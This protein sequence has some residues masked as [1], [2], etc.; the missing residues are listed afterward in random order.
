MRKTSIKKDLIFTL[1]VL[2]AIALIAM[3]LVSFIYSEHHAHEAF[4]ANLVRSAKLIFGLIKHEI[5][6]EKDLNFLTEISPA[7][8]QRIF[9][10]YEYKLHAQAW[11]G[12]ELI[13]NSDNL[14]KSPKP[15]HEGFGDISVDENNWR[16]FS[17]YDS[18]S[19]IRILVAEKDLVRNDLIFEIFLSFLIPLL[20]SLPPLFLI[21]AVTVNKKL[22]PLKNLAAKIEKMSLQ[23][24]QQLQDHDLPSELAP[25]VSSFNSL[26]A[27]L[28][29]LID[30][31]RN[32]TNYAAHELKTP[33]AAISVQ[34]HLL[35]KNKDQELEKKYSQDLFEGINRATH[36]INQLLTLS[37]LEID[38][39]EIEKEVISLK[40]LTKSL[41]K[42][43]APKAE[44]KNLEIEFICEVAAEKNFIK[45][46]KT[47][48]EI[49]LGNLLDNAI[50]YSSRDKKISILIFE[51]NNFL[52]FKISNHGEK[53][54]PEEIEKI[55]NN[56]YRVS[57]VNVD[58]D[59]IGCGLGLAIVKK[60]ASLHLAKVFFESEGGINSVEI[61]FPVISI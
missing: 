8:Q 53:I 55:F 34:A 5:S 37:R 27:R 26:M 60:I 13:Y 49:M 35:V 54:L 41:V 20:L 16:S 48:I 39:S 25:L 15:E 23:T 50:K 14:F 24:I 10:R 28:A 6:D 59:P 4:D 12:G 42:N 2:I 56:F 40:D 3:R 52:N 36:L 22:N 44:K 46:N 30:A 9:H 18:Q 51:K 32:F 38:N 7:L 45:A 29:E 43:F 17:F 61:F 21:I 57:R 19:D 11:K 33:L 47:Y 31:E 1:S 58:D